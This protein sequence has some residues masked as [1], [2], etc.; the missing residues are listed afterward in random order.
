MRIWKGSSGSSKDGPSVPRASTISSE[1]GSGGRKDR[2]V[3]LPWHIIF[4]YQTA[5]K[6]SSASGIGTVCFLP[7]HTCL[8]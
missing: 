6:S 4:F 1:E 3:E 8:K 7:A 5:E 2:R